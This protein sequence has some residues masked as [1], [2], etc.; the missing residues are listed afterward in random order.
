MRSGY[1]V[2]LQLT[3][4]WRRAEH[5]LLQP[6]M[7]E[8]CSICLAPVAA[9]QGSFDDAHGARD[10]PVRRCPRCHLEHEQDVFGAPA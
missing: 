1:G 9:H 8:R 2:D 10:I 6:A 7:S 4:W 5:C 3:L